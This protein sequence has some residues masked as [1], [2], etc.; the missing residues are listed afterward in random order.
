MRKRS[1]GCDDLDQMLIE[2]LDVGD[3]P[4]DATARKPPQHRIFQQSRG[5]LGGDFLGAELATDGEHLDQPVR[6]PAPAAVPGV[7]A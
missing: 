5:I 6:Q 7:S 1:I 4:R 3:E 2:H